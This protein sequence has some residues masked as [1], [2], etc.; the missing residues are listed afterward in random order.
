MIK[1]GE[2]P[3]KIKGTNKFISIKGEG[4]RGVIL[5]LSEKHDQAIILATNSSFDGSVKWGHMYLIIESDPTEYPNLVKEV[6]FIPNG[7][8]LSSVVWKE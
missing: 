8:V 3:Q 6:K 1:V 4:N 5:A 7:F 2:N